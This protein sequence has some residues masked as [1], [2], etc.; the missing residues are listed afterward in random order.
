MK[1]TIGI[2]YYK[3]TVLA[4]IIFS[5]AGCSDYF[6]NPLVDKETGEDINLLVLDFNF[7]TTRMTYK[8]IDAT[9]GAII[10][11]DALIMFSGKNAN[12]I[13]SFG[14]DK[15]ENY[16][17]TEGR[18]E[19]TIDPN[20]PISSSSPFE[21]AVNVDIEGYNSLA[22]GIQINSEGNKTI[23]LFFTKT[24]DEEES[25]LTGGVEIDNG[26]TTFYFIAPFKAHLKSAR[27]TKEKEYNI[28]HTFVMDDLMQFRDKN[29]QAIFA[30]RKEAYEAYLSDSAN[31]IKVSIY[32]LSNYKQEIDV[33]NFGDEVKSAL[34]HKIETGRLSRLRIAG[35]L[36]FSIGDGKITSTCTDLKDFLPN[37]LNFVAFDSEEGHWNLLGDNTVHKDLRFKYTLASVSQEDL[38]DTGGT[39]T[40]KSNILSSFSIDADV[41]DADN[42]FIT[43]MNFKGNFPETFELENVPKGA[44][45]LVFRNNNPAFQEIPP[46]NIPDFCNGNDEVTVAPTSG[47]VEYRIVLKALCQNN[48]TVAIAPSYSAEFRLK[49]TEDSWQG[50]YM[51]GGVVDI[52]GKPSA[53]YEL[54]LLWEDAWEYSAYFTMFN[55]D[56]SYNG[57]DEA[58]AKVTS[59]RLD[60]GRMQINV[61]KI[62]KQNICDDLGW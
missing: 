18:L 7:F 8:L 33:V 17:T 27:G 44:V 16:Q 62:F 56:G 35:E 32:S 34:F 47:Y 42:K 10:N 19:L 43:S 45:K 40:F 54:R 60:D 39:I 4:I 13:V 9:T 36:V 37:I 22:K 51:V 14:G 15:N 59:K 41:Y 12:D 31:F 30:S 26:D 53:E 38:C 50:I 23:E 55:E 21:F 58:D 1:K 46:L 11:K 49:N 57:P 28:R 6:K 48:K 61:E 3:L 52:L 2:K 29:N 24:E 20:I 25:E 5:I